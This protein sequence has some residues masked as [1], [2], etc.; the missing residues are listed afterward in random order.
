M[1]RTITIILAIGFLVLAGA[2]F[3]YSDFGSQEA[4]NANGH[5][6]DDT[7]IL[8]QTYE[9]ERF[10]YRIE[11]PSTFQ[12]ESKPTNDD[13]R[14]FAI[15][16]SSVRVFARNNTDNSSFNEVLSQE[17]R[18][19]KSLN[20]ANVGSTTATLFGKKQNA[21]V[22]KKI[23]YRPGKIGVVEVTGNSEYISSSS[24]AHVLDSFAW[25]DSP[26]A[27]PTSTPATSSSDQ[28]DQRS[29]RYTPEA[30]KDV[31]SVASPTPDQVISSPL[32]ISGQARGQWL[33]EANAPVELESQDGQ[34]IA[35]D[36]ITA[37]SP[38]MTEDFVPFS[39]VLEFSRPENAGS[40]SARGL[41][42]IRRDNP[43]GQ[44]EHDMAVK[45]P[46]RFQR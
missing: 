28:A 27:M 17:T 3:V 19:L 8:W 20:D 10:G 46:V 6:H 4:G 32:E 18:N 39:G 37:E 33:F 24:R 34:T 1:R 16:S 5:T 42:I 35:E 12:T 22:A 45:I 25:T 41:L 36:T 15:S 13:G 44:P 14:T 26:E 21:P 11:V 7:A 40:Q 30:A 9:N 23:I 29:I 43:S 2:I 31:I 38:W